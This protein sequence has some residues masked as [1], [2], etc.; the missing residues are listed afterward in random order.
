MF[1]IVVDN[2]VSGMVGVMMVDFDYCYDYMNF[3]IGVFEV[4]GL[5]LIGEYL[6]CVFV[7]VCNFIGSMFGYGG[8]ER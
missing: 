8:L 7:G 1:I 4:I 6:V 2:I 3:M 5:L